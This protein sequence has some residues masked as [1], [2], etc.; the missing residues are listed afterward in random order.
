MPRPPRRA[1]SK[2]V[3]RRRRLRIL[4]LAHASRGQG[5]RS[6]RR[7]VGQRSSTIYRGAAAPGASADARLRLPGMFDDLCVQLVQS[8]ALARSGVSHDA[9]AR[10]ARRERAV[11]R[12]RPLTV[13]GGGS[14]RSANSAAAG[15]YEVVACSEA[16]GWPQSVVASLQLRARRR[17]RHERSAPWRGHLRWS[18]AHGPPEAPTQTPA[19]APEQDGRSTRPAGTRSLRLKLLRYLGKETSTNSWRVVRRRRRGRRST[20]VSS[21]PL[22]R[23]AAP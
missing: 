7:E 8:S 1:S 19:R 23:A 9:R 12:S 17:S 13:L 5:P 20:P 21:I 14:G 3:Q 10:G 18:R 15:T 6:R 16:P 11:D 2:S 4:Y 22:P